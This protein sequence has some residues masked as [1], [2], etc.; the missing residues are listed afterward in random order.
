VC[1]GAREVRVRVLAA[2]PMVTG[3]EARDARRWP[4]PLSMRVVRELVGGAGAASTGP[5]AAS[6][7]LAE[8][9][10]AGWNH[11][12]GLKQRQWRLDRAWVYRKFTP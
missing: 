12:G 10:N 7:Y 9:V 5:G 2:P 4:R 1:T 8:M 6:G 3:P 11:A